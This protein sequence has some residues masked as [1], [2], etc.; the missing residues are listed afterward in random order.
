MGN[1]IDPEAGDFTYTAQTTHGP[2]PVIVRATD[3]RGASATATFNLS[4]V[5]DTTAPVVTVTITPRRAGIGQ[6]VAIVISTIEATTDP[7]IEVT[8]TNRG[9]TT[10][11]V[12]DL[13]GQITYTPEG[14]GQ[15]V[16]EVTA[17]DSSGNVGRATES[18]AVPDPTDA[19]PPV[20]AIAS[21]DY[22]LAHEL[23]HVSQAAPLVGLDIYGLDEA[24]ENAKTHPISATTMA[25][26]CATALYFLRHERPRL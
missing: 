5:P 21:V 18:F 10:S 23:A 14:T 22:A 3:P 2:L 8:V 12:P 13:S 7:T 26:N 1:D 11:L 16:I 15:Y 17:T 25:E 6:P 20:V 9:V 4:T 24:S 19:T